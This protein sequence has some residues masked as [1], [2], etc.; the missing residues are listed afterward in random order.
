MNWFYLKLSLQAIWFILP[1]YFANAVPAAISKFR[2]IQRYNQ[3]IDSGTKLDGKPI[4]GRGKTWIGIFAGVLTGTFVG[5][6]QSFFPGTPYM[7]VQLACLLSIGALVGD[8]VKSLIKRRIG[9][10]SGKPWPFFDQIDFLIGA[11]AFSLFV[12]EMNWYYFGI[13]L[14]ITPI[15]HYLANYLGWKLGL[16]KVPW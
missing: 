12:T 6:I 14:I 3:P 13:L 9:I 16:K 8:M 7:T 4:L 5:Y 15:A 10:R 2:E 11:F 1:A